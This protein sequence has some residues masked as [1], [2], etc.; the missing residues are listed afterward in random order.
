MARDIPFDIVGSFNK[1]FSTEFDPQELVNCFVDT[2]PQG[3][4]GKA[5][6]YTPGLNLT[7]GAKIQTGKKGRRLYKFKRL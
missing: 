2:D 4:K 6:L 5:I 3:K 1:S 7:A